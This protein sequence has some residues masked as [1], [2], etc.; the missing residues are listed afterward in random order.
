MSQ[1]C[2]T[3]CSCPIAHSHSTMADKRTAN[4]TRSSYDR[5]VCVGICDRSCDRSRDRVVVTRFALFRR[6]VY[7]LLIASDS[8]DH[9]FGPLVVWFGYGLL[10]KVLL[11]VLV[12]FYPV[13][14]S[15]VEGLML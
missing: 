5:R 13:A 12:V 6:A 14:V 4:L 2:P 11:V 7:P 9:G 8:S 15:T 1:T 10:P 3:G